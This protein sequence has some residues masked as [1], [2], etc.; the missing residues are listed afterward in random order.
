MRGS[1]IGT[2]SNCSALQDRD[3]AGFADA[4]PRQAEHEGIE[5]RAGQRQCRAGIAEARRTCRCAAG[6]QPATRRCRRARAPSCGWRGGWR[7]GR[8]GA[9]ARRRR[10]RPRAPARLR[11]R[12]ACPAARRPATPQS[13]RITAAARAS[14]PRSRPRP[15]LGQITFIVTAPRRSSTSMSRRLWTRQRRRCNRHRHELAWLGDSH[16]RAFAS[17]LPPAVH[18]VGVDAVRHRYLGHR[19]AGRLALGQYLRLELFAV[20]PP[21]HHLVA[22]HRVH[23]EVAWTRSFT[24]GRLDSRWVRRTHTQ[25]HPCIVKAHQ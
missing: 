6:A 3:D 17:Q 10:R 24:A 9:A 5:L 25:H 1:R 7:T 22:C 12:R 21:S 18:D 2:F 20:A 15:T 13:T 23:L 4:L 19:G 11:C 14:R 8:R 16:L